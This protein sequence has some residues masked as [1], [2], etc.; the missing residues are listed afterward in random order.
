MKTIRHIRL[1][2]TIYQFFLITSTLTLVL[3]LGA[4]FKLYHLP[5]QHGNPL[6][7]LFILNVV[8]CAVLWLVIRRLRC[9]ICRNVFVGAESPR[10]HTTKCRHCGRR[11]GDTH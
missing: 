5:A 9:P 10:L 6:G 8:I 11:S 4:I 1:V 2:Q 3:F 7:Q